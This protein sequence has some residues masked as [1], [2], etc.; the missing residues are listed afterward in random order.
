M[1]YVD[2]TATS[3]S[4]YPGGN[5]GLSLV[6]SSGTNYFYCWVDWNGDL[7]FNDAGETVVATTS[8]TSSYAST[9]LQVPAGTAVGSYRMRVALSEISA[10][11]ACGPAPYGNY[12]DYTFNVVAPPTCLPPTALTATGL[13]YTGCL[14]YTS[15]AAD[16]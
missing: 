12:M 16:D 5:F 13:S 9:S 8:Y 6:A 3:C 14:L 11:T 1:A 7:D 15:D 10:I 2:N 4:Q